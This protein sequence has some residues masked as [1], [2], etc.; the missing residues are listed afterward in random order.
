MTRSNSGYILSQPGFCD[1]SNVELRERREKNDSNVLSS[2]KGGA[3]TKI[4][5]FLLVEQVV[6]KNSKCLVLDMLSLTSKWSCQ[7]DSW[8]DWP[9]I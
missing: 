3:T 4:F 2:W 6:G 5:G 8:I 1:L 7:V 9:G